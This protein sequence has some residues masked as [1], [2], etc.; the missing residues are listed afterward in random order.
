MHFKFPDKDIMLIRDCNILGPVEGQEPGSIWTLVF[1]GS[2]NAQGNGIGE[3]ITSP[4][5]F[6]LPFIARLCFA[7]TKNMTEYEACI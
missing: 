6:H 1:D 5:G 4:S 3:I 7:C 2:S